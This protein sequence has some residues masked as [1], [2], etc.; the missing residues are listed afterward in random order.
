MSTNSRFGPAF[1]VQ[2]GFFFIHNL[3][4]LALKLDRQNIRNIQK[5]ENLSLVLEFSFWGLFSYSKKIL[6][7]K[8]VYVVYCVYFQNNNNLF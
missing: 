4:I 2:P 7:S 8:V 5:S 3:S 1:S 6:F